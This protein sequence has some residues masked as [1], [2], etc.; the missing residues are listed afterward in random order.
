[1]SAVEKPFWSI[2]SSELFEQLKTTPEGLTNDEVQRRLSSYGYNRLQ[3][4]KKTDVL[5]LFLNQ[6][7]SPLVLI[8]LFAAILSIFLQD[9]TSATI[10]LV[11]VFVSGILGFWQERGATD[12]VKKLLS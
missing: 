7:R 6:F 1:M 3:V 9:P 8:L 5:T 11:I 2:P 10:I 4:K 12:A